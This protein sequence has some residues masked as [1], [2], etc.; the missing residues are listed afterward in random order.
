MLA[1]LLLTG[2]FF[3]V[4]EVFAATNTTFN[5]SFKY[6]QET[7]RWN[8]EWLP[9]DGTNTVTVQWH[10]PD[11]TQTTKT[12]L[13]LVLTENGKN[14]ISLEF[15]PDHIYDLHFNFKNQDG[16][17]VSFRNKYNE[18]V[19][20][21]IIYF[22]SD[23][24]FEGTSFNEMAVLGGLTDSSPNLVMSADGTQVIR[25][26]SGQQPK[27]T[28]RWKVPT[29]WDP[30]ERRIL[31][32]TDRRVNLNRLES[33][34]TPH[35]DIDYSYFHVK[36]NVVKDIVTTKD[37]RTAYDNTGSVIVRETGGAVS[38]LNASGEVISSDGYVSYTFDH[39]THGIIPGT[40]YEKVNIRL[41]FWNNTQNEQAIS[42]R[43]VYGFDSGQGFPIENKDNVFQSIE[44]RIDSLFTPMMYEVS[45]VDVDKIEIRIYKIKSRNYTELYYQ[46]QDA[47]TVVELLETASDPGTGIKV[48]DTSIPG[49]TGWGSVIVEIPLD[50]TGRHPEHYYRVVV[51][52]GN[53]HTPLG[54]LAI[55]LRMLGN[56]TGKPPVPREI[57]VEP[58]YEGKKNVTYG[59]N[60]ADGETVRI[61]T[62]NLKLS[63]EKPLLWM[64]REWGDILSEPDNDNDF[65][66]HILLNTFLS[67]NVKIMETRVIGEQKVTVYV[68]VKEKRILTIDK[69]D[70]HEDPNDSSRLVYTLDG[71]K[72][73]WDYTVGEPEEPGEPLTKENDVDADI[74]QLPDYPGFLLPNTMY[75]LR[76]FSTRRKDN[77]TVNWAANTGLGDKISY[78]SPVVSFTTFPSEDLPVP[79]P[80]LVLGVDI[81]PEP[82]PA[83]GKPVFNGITVDFPKILDDN[84]WLEYTDVTENRKLVYDLY[85]SSSTDEDSFVLLQPPYM[86]SLQTLYPDENPGSGI[87]TL[88]TRFPAG[89]GEALKPN[90]TYYFKLQ[91]K[92][93]VNNEA[94]PFLVS[95]FTPIKSITTP[96]TDSG[97]M[98]DLDRKPRTPVEFSIAVKDGQ[99]EL[100]DAKV[101]LNWLHAEQ[102]VVYEMVCTK[103]RLDEDYDYVNDDYHIGNAQAPGFLD[104]YS[105]YKPNATDDQLVINVLNT[106]LKDIGFTYNES[107]TRIA[108]FPANLPFLRPNT[109]YYFSLRAVRNRGQE[110]ASYSDWVSIPVTTKMVAPPEFIEAVNDVQLGF[111]VAIAGIV[112]EEDVRVM[113]KKANQIADIYQELSR[114]KY[115]VVKD[116]RDYY[117]R[118]FD[119]EPN[120]WY[121]ILVYYPQGNTKMWYNS[122]QKTWE[123]TGDSP[124]KMKTRNT[125]NEIEI[126]FAGEDIYDYFMEIRTDYDEDYQTLQYGTAEGSDY[127]YRLADDTE[128]EFYREKVAAYVTGGL[129]EKYVY[130]AKISSSMQRQPDGTFKRQPLLANT[131]YYVKVWAR[132]ISD[133]NHIG[134]VSVRTD[135]SQDD[136]DKDRVRDEITHLFQS[137]ADGLTRKLYFTVNEPDKT[138]N[139][140]LLK[141]S[142]ISGML[143]VAGYSGVTVDISAEKAETNRDIILIP[144]EV[145]SVLQKVNSRLTI[146]MAEGELTLS[147]ETLNLETI[148]NS[149]TAYG[150]KETMLELTIDRNLA[151]SVQPPQGL[152]VSSKVF[153]ISMRAVNMKRTYAEMNEIIYDILKKPT[154]TGPFKYGLLD[155]E[156]YKLLGEKTTLT[157]KSQAELNGLIDL[158]VDRIEEELSL[159]IRD[160][161]D[162]GRGFSASRINS[163][164]LKELAG[165]MKLKM[166][167]DGNQSL[168]QPMFLPTGAAIWQ[169]P[170]GIKAWL[171]PYVLVNCKTPGQYAVFSAP[172]ISIAIPDDGV[173]VNPDLLRLSHKYDLQ[174]VFG[175]QTLYPGDFVSKDSAV[176]LFEVVT[177]TGVMGL[178]TPAKIKHYQLDQF[179]P[180][181]GLKT[182]INRQQATSLVVEIYAYKSGVSA[183]DLRPAVHRYIR[184]AAVM[185]DPVYHRLVIALDL[186]LTGLEPD[187][188]YKGESLATIE[189]ILQ[190]IIMVLDLLGEW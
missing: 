131:R 34:T 132:N 181:S 83:T 136:Y 65:T 148:K 28:L 129:N 163:H 56:D 11:G 68:P 82:D 5:P 92:L 176:T 8:I 75:Y 27:L 171:F 187:N 16:N 66:F 3:A 64:T 36:M 41:Y 135:F 22:L 97:S 154:A 15:S 160:I 184:N 52:D 37:Y 58:K 85:I 108:R 84:D 72:L 55:D 182:N 80:N 117:I 149:S 143:K 147:G 49:S 166:L 119:L 2:L 111:K 14:I 76:M 98:D 91:A 161:L 167:H 162:G 118:L 25:I 105:R 29:I 169:D 74:N 106:R 120:T 23:M 125:L 30:S 150:I 170:P 51:T 139:R 168:A 20:E 126:R 17:P 4:Q 99:P 130:Y 95:D 112:K 185:P 59:N 116:G 33:N 32:I 124:L 174:K 122:S 69:H 183:S 127:G 142:T 54:S 81:A 110:D 177:E 153:D 6:D 179:L 103:E 70:L 73:F 7:S 45:K 77:D 21:D 180:V 190:E 164:E 138:A 123:A 96:K 87:S 63:F 79:M 155:R 48:P 121:D 10:E 31:D 140:I 114:A 9:V 158:L 173:S 133:S 141:G 50:Q 40:E 134:P 62:T 24:T 144:M 44:G 90:T 26:I 47:G 159:Y 78:I 101:T 165:G 146:H 189:E 145:L 46:V 94:D 38:G 172:V 137:R 128:I 113:V 60:Q 43:L 53:S 178:S 188:S 89:S 109:L 57:Q 1:A 186:G 107:F 88:V 102:D 93:Y 100:T 115:S 67:D 12:D 151:G 35:V 86:D 156:L 157:Y 152:T 39:Q 42:S 13:P 18:Q 104:V 175:S 71:T 19:A 61:P